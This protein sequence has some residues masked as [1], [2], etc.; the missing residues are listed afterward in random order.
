MSI[1]WTEEDLLRLQGRI[2]TSIAAPLESKPAKY[3]NRRVRWQ[4]MMFD[5]EHELTKYKEFKLQELAG[6]IRSVVRQVSMP[7]SGSK[8]RIRLDFMIV[9]KNGQIRWVDAKGFSTPAWE[10]KRDQIQ[11]AYGINIETV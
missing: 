3:R 11:S 4:G 2:R 6:E 7:L 1:R 5:S 10:C 8:R 9:E